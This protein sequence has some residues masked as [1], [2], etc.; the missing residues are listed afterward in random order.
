MDVRV[1]VILTFA[2]FNRT[3]LEL[4]RTNIACIEF[5]DNTFNRTSLELKHHI[6]CLLSQK[7]FTFNRTSLELKLEYRLFLPSKFG[8]TS[9]RTSL[10]LKPLSSWLVV[11]QFIAPLTL[12]IRTSLELKLR[13]CAI[14]AHVRVSAFNRTSKESQMSLYT[15]GEAFDFF[16]VL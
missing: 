15:A 1:F 4:K 2:T 8:V 14:A 6:L 10:E 13:T 9:N 7:Q 12:L 3:S 5:L 11:A 16:Y